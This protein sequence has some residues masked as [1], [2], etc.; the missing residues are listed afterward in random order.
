MSGGAL[1]GLGGNALAAIVVRAFEARDQPDVLEV[2]RAAFGA[3]PPDVRG[4]A[5]DDFFRWKHFAGPFGASMLLVVES[6]DTVI[7]FA[8]YM[9]SRFSAG[10]Q[11]VAAMRGTDFV[12]HPSHQGRGASFA[13]ARAA[14]ERFPKDLAFVWCNPNEQSAPVTRKSGWLPVGAL[15]RFLRPAGRLGGTVRRARARGSRTPE[16]LP[17][18]ADSAV[19]ILRDEQ[20]ASQVLA[21]TGESDDRLSTAKQLD[22]LRW[23]YGQFAEYRAIRSG[24]DAGGGGAGMAIF[25]PR[26]RGPFWVL[27]VCELLVEPRDRRTAQRLLRRVREAAPA[28]FLSCS[29]SSPARAA[30]FGFLQARHR[31]VL[32]TLPIQSDTVPDPTRLGSWALSLGDRELL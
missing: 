20:H 24:A 7:G 17:V 15:P 3:W 30:R 29:F 9:P 25:K 27:E 18:D 2:L 26:R 32:F 11:T 23:R 22:Y 1:K 14:I 19:E 28:D 10:G 6:E 13:L 16:E 12:I 31:E 5:A 8:G 21:S 4:V